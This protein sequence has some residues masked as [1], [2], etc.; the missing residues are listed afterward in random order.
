MNSPRLLENLQVY[1][2]VGSRRRSV[3]GLVAS[4][5]SA[6]HPRSAC[7]Y[8]AALLQDLGAELLEPQCCVLTL[9]SPAARADGDAGICSPVM[10]SPLGLISKL[11]RTVNNADRSQH[12]HDLLM[13]P[14]EDAGASYRRLAALRA[15]LFE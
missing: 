12:E 4:V 7:P 11:N 2:P 9:V 15:E 6:A 10:S 8:R 1:L 3:C 13:L 14:G 5:H